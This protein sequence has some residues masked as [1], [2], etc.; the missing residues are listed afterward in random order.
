MV[1]EGRKV[2]SLWD[3]TVILAGGIL[4][5]LLRLQGEI[6][7]HVL[8]ASGATG[9]TEDQKK[10][11]VAALKLLE[12]HCREQQLEKTVT[13]I[14]ELVRDLQFVAEPIYTEFDREALEPKADSVFRG[15]D[16]VRLLLHEELGARKL[17]FIPPDEQKFLEPHLFGEVVSV[18]FDSAQPD[19]KD[20][21]GCLAANLPNAAIFHLMRVAELGLRAFAKRLKVALPRH[22]EYASW[23]EVIN[24]IQGKLGKINTKTVRGDRQAKFYG[25][26]VLDIRV[27]SYLWRNPIMHARRWYDDHGAKK[28]FDSVRDFMQKL[29]ANGIRVKSK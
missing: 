19:I 6:D 4:D 2:L 23:G 20:A 22:I 29:E 26:L 13:R 1:F 18:A 16:A 24:A 5:D 9:F 28:A 25:G 11:L 15:C 21:G 12:A 17:I 3:M 27:F 10:R 8:E 7:R 14:A